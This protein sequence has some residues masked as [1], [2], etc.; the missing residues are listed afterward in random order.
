MAPM[1]GEARPPLPVRVGERIGLLEPAPPPLPPGARPPRH[2]FRWDLDKTYLRTEFDS[3][4]RPREERDRDR[5]RQAG[6][7]RARPRCSARCA[8]TAI[9]ICIVS[10]SPDADAPGARREAR[11]RRRR[12]RRVRPQEQP[13]EHPARP[14]PRAARADPVQAA[15]DAA[16]ADRRAAAERETLFGDDAEADAIIYCL[17]ADLVAGNVS[18]AR[19]RARARS[20]RAPTTTTPSA[21][22]TL[23]ARGARTAD[24][25]RRM[26]IHLDRRSPAAGLPPVRRRAWSRSSTTS[27]PRSCSTRTSVLTGAP[28]HLRR[29]RDARL[30]AV[31]ARPPRDQRPGR[32]PA[33]PDHAR[34][35]ARSSPPRPTKRRPPARFGPHATCRRSSGSPRRFASEFASLAPHTRPSE[36]D[37]EP[38]DYVRLVDEEHEH[39]HRR[40]RQGMG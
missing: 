31:R 22:S 34:D 32:H 6:V 18:L 27:R 40:R 21:A 28:G 24:A 9:A 10:G 38:L 26:F 36:P 2:T 15:G 19:P 16:L 17:Y 25:V 13:Q 1:L 14:V 35:R 4:A 29:A 3:L 33:R 5:R 7:S 30:R 8:R 11:A 37:V 39:R 23:A 20:R 12:V